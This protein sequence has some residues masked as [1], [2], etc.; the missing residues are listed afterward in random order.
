MHP[1]PIL[2]RAGLRE[3]KTFMSGLI[4]DK[5][6]MPSAPWGDCLTQRP[7]KV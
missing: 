6:A 2:S 3:M 7:H 5:S 4:M 1:V